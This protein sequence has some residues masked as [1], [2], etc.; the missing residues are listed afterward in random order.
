MSEAFKILVGI[1]L[2]ANLCAWAN[3]QCGTDWL[4]NHFKL[5]QSQAAKRSVSLF[6]TTNCE[7]EFYFDSTK[8]LERE[9]VHF[10]IYYVLDGP[11]ATTEIF[12]DSLTESLEN[13]W[14][15]HIQKRR[16]KIPKGANPTW[17]YKKSGDESRYPVE[18]ID[19]SLMRNNAEY[20]GGF[21]PACLGVTFPP[22]A[23][24]ALATEIL[25]DND[26]LYPDESSLAGFFRDP[27]C[28]Y[29]KADKAI[30]NATTGK[31][32]KDR[33]G[34]ALR[35]TTVHEFYHAIQAM[36]LNFFDY[37]SYWLEA[38]ATAAEEL[39]YPEVNDY[40]AYLSSFFRSAGT[41]FNEIASDYGLAIW[42]L[43]NAVNIDSLL[44]I[45]LWERL[46]QDP[47]LPFESVFANE[48]IERELNPDSVFWDFA[49]R[50]FFSGSRARAADSSLYFSNDFLHWPEAP[51]LRRATTGA[52]SLRP[53]AF[54]FIQITD[55]SIPDLSQFQ[56]KAGIALYG[57]RQKAAFYS[58]DTVSV[59]AIAPLINHSE[60]AVL[61][62]SRLQEN[63]ETIFVKDTLPMR[64]YPNPWRG[65][66]P[67]CFAGLPEDRHF[68][69]IRTRVGKLIKRFPY[70]GSQ[71]CLEVENLKSRMAPGL[72]VF[73]AGSQSRTKPFLVIY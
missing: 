69:E 14:N 18:V 63:S 11:H 43:Y 30:I 12:I 49:S 32:Y 45:R 23:Q 58:L 40:W 53:P 35:I 52:V 22:D 42:G 37:T 71:L 15:F 33:F 47:N 25:I 21:C 50:I 10:R 17:H 48:L 73:R 20:F 44:D 7:P 13:A 67:L 70:A 54:D 34:E 3:S 6:S 24:N 16:A 1:F 31:N 2:S 51:P 26:F 60:N 72:Y 36:Y 65:E 62:L 28:R 8:V 55:D 19:L 9:T 59:A 41:P 4:R 29:P 64:V 5:P 57:D 56:G 38:S 46:S 61:I 27:H 66:T 68:V 39:A